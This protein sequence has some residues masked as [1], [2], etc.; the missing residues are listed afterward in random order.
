MK[1]CKSRICMASAAISRTL[2]RCNSPLST[3]TFITPC[4]I[5]DIQF[6]W[7][8]A[9]NACR[10]TCPKPHEFRGFC[11]PRAGVRGNALKHFR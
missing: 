6:H 10:P 4:S 1:E 7:Q 2:A 5:F 8:C 3:S 9:T 11:H